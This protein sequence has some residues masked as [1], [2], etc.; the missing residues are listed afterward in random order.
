MKQQDQSFTLRSLTFKSNSKMIPFCPWS[1]FSCICQV[2]SL[3]SDKDQTRWMIKIQ[4]HTSKGF[5][6]NPCLKSQ[7]SETWRDG[8]WLM[9]VCVV[10][11]VVVWTSLSVSLQSSIV[12]PTL[13]PYFTLI[14]LS[15]SVSAQAALD[16]LRAVC[17][18]VHERNN[19]WARDH[20]AS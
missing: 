14:S 6:S 3:D 19:N 16:E 12:H 15:V 8:S 13:R 20:L 1:F 17:A 10:E 2:I 11:Q 7:T 9:P 5:R 18:H 4:K